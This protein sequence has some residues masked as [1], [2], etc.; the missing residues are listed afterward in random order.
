MGEAV[1]QGGGHLGIAED[2]GPFAEAEVCGDDDAG[3]LVEMGWLPPSPD[4]IAMCQ[5]CDVPHHA[6]ER[7]ANGRYD[8]W[9]GPCKERFSTSRG[10]YDGA[11]EVPEKAD[12]TPVP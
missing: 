10:H 6:T 8:N 7:A 11:A 9:R 1:E 2:R 3:A 5:D 4:G 12:A